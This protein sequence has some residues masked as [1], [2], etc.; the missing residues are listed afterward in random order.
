MAHRL[1][2]RTVAV[3]SC[4][5]VIGDGLHKIAFAQECRR[6]FPDARV[7]WIAGLGT[8]VYASHLAPMVDGLIDEVVENA[9]IGTPGQLLSPT[10][11]LEGRR[12]DLVV[13]TQRHVLRSLAARRIRHGAFLSSTAGFW[14]SSVR[15]AD[16]SAFPRSLLGQFAFLLDLVSDPP[17]GAPEPIRIGAAHAG[18]A[19]EL[20]P[21]GPAYIGLSPGAGDR[22]KI[23]PLDRFV[24]LARR[25]AAAGRVPV[26][27]LGPAE[28][29]LRADL[30]EAVPDALIPEDPAL[31]GTAPGGPPL[32]TAMGARMTAAV[33][34]DSGIGHMLAY[35][36]VPLVA[37]YSKAD[38]RKYV[39]NVP[40]LAVIDSKTYGGPD[41][42][43]VP[44]E[45]VAAALD[46]LLAGGP[47]S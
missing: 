31:S 41:P 34:N 26:F 14:L 24:A 27:I 11:P 44:L 20:L 46:G 28:Q 6:R 9:G 18:R 8:S 40:H 21:D 42:S 30:A 29:D 5:E 47:T 2:P 23:W 25:Q 35:A 17:A 15:P 38:P 36:Q 12:F 7:T 22:S 1:D 37:I 45:D 19:A 13:D 43:L 3:Y 16:P 10:A 33:A 39:L 32:I 4:G